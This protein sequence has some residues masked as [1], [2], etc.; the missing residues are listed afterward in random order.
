MTVPAP[1]AIASLVR[2]PAVLS[3]PGDPLLGA[4]ASG[5]QRSPAA[6]AALLASSCCLY[7]G[8][9]AL[10]DYADREVDAVER[11]TRPI[12][13]GR[14]TPR[15]ALGLGS[16][17]LAAGLALA[18]VGGGRQA[19]AVAAPLAGTVLAYDL[20][21]KDTPAGPPAMAAARFLDVLLGA[22]PGRR[23]QALPAA[24]IVGAHTLK[25]T[26]VS[27]HEVQGAHSQVGR[28][29]LLGTA[30]V[31]AA[32]AAFAANR[33][34]GVS[35]SRLGRTALAAGLLG[36]YA[37]SSAM[38]E[39]HAARQPTPGA[40]QR[41]VGTGVLN[42]L[43]LESGLHAASGGPLPASVGVAAAWPFARALAR[44]RAVT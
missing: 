43:P 20:A 42:L 4:A 14:V 44:R 10:N 31:T 30:G 35:R 1:S 37:A 15:F 23:R 11:P 33:L 21:L 28:R 2:L 16:G 24:G 26:L 13:S 3:A 6:T 41:A 36:S 9:M 38:A 17:L 5:A 22:A 40:L 27:Q 8:G 19:I 29:A 25:I 18:G 34:R 7:L 32:A 12:P 39:D